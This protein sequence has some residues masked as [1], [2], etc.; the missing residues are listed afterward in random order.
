MFVNLMR[1]NQR[2]LMGVISVLVIIS[3]IWFYS[4]RTQVDRIVSDRVGS[5][6]GRNLTSIEVDRV[7]RQLQ[8]AR[9]LGLSNLVDRDLIGR[10]DELDPVAAAVVNHLVV[11]HQAEAMGIF[12]TN[13]EVTEAVQKLP[14]FQT[15]SGQFDPARY[16]EFVSND[17]SPRGFSEDQLAELVREDLQFGR[18]RSVV[19]APV[20]V[21]PV[22]LQLAYE[23]AYAKTNAS[24]IRLMTKDFSAGVKEPTDDEVKKYFED[25]KEQ[26]IQPEKRKVA[27]VRFGLTDEQKKLV[28]KEKMDVLQ[29]LANQAV[30]VLTDLLDNKDKTDF[31]AAAA[32]ANVP[33][34]ETVDFERSQF[35]G[36]AEASIPGFTQ[37]A[38]KLSKDDPD[39]DVPLQTPDAFYDLHL[40]T[41]TPP[42]PL[43][44]EE[45]RPK[46]VEAIKDERTRA[47]LSARAEEI[48][49]KVADALKA[50]RSFADAAKEAGQSAQEVP[51]YSKV[52]PA[53][54]TPDAAAIASTTQELGVGELSKFVPTANGGLLAFVRSREGID[55]AQFDQEKAIDQVR[56]EQQKA[57]FYF[58]DWLRVSR[59]AANASIIPRGG[60]G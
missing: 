51:A 45:A 42:R 52:D 31:A 29:P 11:A 2:W 57:G 21:S 55:Q 36:F 12:P 35:G 20:V 24:I 23:E 40:L 3:F 25:Q 22:S 54:S 59:E 6:Y 33:V 26:Y 46:V 38:F 10:G 28:G 50:G 18:L 44:L 30:A 17:L 39:S 15:S 9:E 60:R 13:D 43:T 58:S 48:R 47:A 5:I 37:A 56:L 4:D 34:E 16:A 8:T 14:K 7:N 32:R 1:S 19:D 27:Y 41:V 49:T 53:R